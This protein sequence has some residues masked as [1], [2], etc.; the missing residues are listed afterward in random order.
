M[1]KSFIY[2]TELILKEYD[3]PLFQFKQKK[4]QGWWPSNIRKQWLFF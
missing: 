3:L 4:L 1:K 2:H